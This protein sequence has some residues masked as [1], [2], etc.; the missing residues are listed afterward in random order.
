MQISEIASKIDEQ[1]T[2]IWRVVDHYTNEARSRED[3]SDVAVI[4]IDETSCTKGH[5]YITLVVDFDTS[6]VIHVCGGKD[7]STLSSFKEDYQTHGG[8]PDNI[9]SVCCDMSPAFISGIKTEFPSASITFDKFHVMKI[10][11]EGIDAVRKEEVAMNQCLKN[12]RYLWLKNPCNLTE[13]QKKTLGSLKD[14]NLKTVRAYNLKLSLQ[15]FWSTGERGVAEQYLKR[16]YFWATH[17]RLQPMI[18][19]CFDY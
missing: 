5:K 9:Y 8:N 6:G 13:K 1:D 2:R 18:D 3:L 14:M 16:W 15:I 11:N 7:S 10:V 17:S 4:G 19:A 12:T